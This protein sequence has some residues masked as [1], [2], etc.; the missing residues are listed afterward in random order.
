MPDPFGSIYYDQFYNGGAIAKNIKPYK[1]EGPGNHFSCCS[2]NLS[3]I[4]K[5]IQFKDED[6]FNGCRNLSRRHG[7]LAGSS[8][9]ANYYVAELLMLSL[10]P[11]IPVNILILLPDSGMKYLL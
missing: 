6:A 4:D 11:K 1:V 9:G 2:M 8:S 7:I 3:Y 10:N 5:I